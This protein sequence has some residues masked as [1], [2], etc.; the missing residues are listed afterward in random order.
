MR[1]EKKIEQYRNLKIEYYLTANVQCPSL[2]L[3]DQIIVL[4]HIIQ[5]D[6]ISLSFA[7]NKL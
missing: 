4:L 7:S 2:L 5:S 1:R 3:F 6:P